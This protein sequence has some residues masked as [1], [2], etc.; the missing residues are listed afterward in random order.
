MIQ[1]TTAAEVLSRRST[2]RC[3]APAG[4]RSCSSTTEGAQSA[5]YELASDA[6]LDWIP[7]TSEWVAENA[8]AR[9]A[10]MADVNTRELSGVDPKKQARVSRARQAADGDDRCGARPRASTAGR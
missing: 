4:C 7:P 8:D 5:F 6:Q 3:C 2:R 9:I 1:S 10:I